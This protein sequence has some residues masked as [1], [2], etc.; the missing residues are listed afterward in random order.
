[1]NRIKAKRYPYQ[2]LLSNAECNP[3]YPYLVD[4]EGEA[5]MYHISPEHGRSYL[6]G[7]NEKGRYVVSKGNG[8]SY[9]SYQFVNTG[10]FGADT[11]G[12]LLRVDA[13]RDYL[14]CHDIADTGI[15]TNWMEY[16]IELQHSLVLPDGRQ[17]LPILLQYSVECPYRICDAPYMESK[18]MVY[19]LSRWKSVGSRTYHHYHLLAADVMIHNLKVMHEAG[20]LHNAIHAH[21]YTWALELLDFE[22]ACSPQHP[23]ARE[24]YNRHVKDL[25]PREILQ[26]YQIV[27]SIAWYLRES[28]D[29]TQIDGIFR[30]YGL[31]LAKYALEKK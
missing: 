15:K 3:V 18:E 2:L 11:W 30:Y 7:K 1:M 13:E 6:V 25:F 5:F 29:H 31:D 17:L 4:R 19:E 22:L 10:E 12:L 24:D 8:L 26:T 20:I 21:N 14:L 28:I 23:Y 16:V 27:C 9:T